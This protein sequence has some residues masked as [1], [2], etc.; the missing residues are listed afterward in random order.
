VTRL[1]FSPPSTVAS[2]AVT[3]SNPLSEADSVKLELQLARTV[4]RSRFSPPFYGGI[5]RGDPAIAKEET[6]LESS[7]AVR[8]SDALENSDR[9]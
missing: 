9:G 8:D 7:V 5:M 3:R 6:F 2:C 4:T 1:C